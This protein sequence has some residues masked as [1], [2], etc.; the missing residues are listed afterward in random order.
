MINLARLESETPFVLNFAQDAKL[1]EIALSFSPMA[2]YAR[3]ILYLVRGEIFHPPFPSLST[4]SSRSSLAERQ[5]GLKPLIPITIAPNPNDGTFRVRFEG[6]AIKN[7]SFIL[8]DMYGRE[9]LVSSLNTLGYDDITIDASALK[10]G[11][12]YAKIAEGERIIWETKVVI[13]NK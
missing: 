13:Q 3:A 9:A 7:G 8:I 10:D 2:A 6:R 11:I 5:A 4:A 1:R 12:Y